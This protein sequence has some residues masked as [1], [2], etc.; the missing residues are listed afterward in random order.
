LKAIVLEGLSKVPDFKMNG[1]SP[2]SPFILSVSFRGLLGE[3][4]V[5]E[6]DH[7]GYAISSGAACS[8][9]STELSPVLR[10]MGVD[11]ELSRGTVRISFGRANTRESAAGLA[12]CLQYSAE[13]LR[14]MT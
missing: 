6:A 10:A 9:T 4:L 13:K 5:L 7:S 12:A 11:D 3:T 14:T 2:T 8:S 1:E